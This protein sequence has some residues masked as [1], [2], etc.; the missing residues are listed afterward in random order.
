MKKGMSPWV[1]EVRED[2]RVGTV[3]YSPL[4]GF[5]VLISLNGTFQMSYLAL[6][7][8]ILSHCGSFRLPP[9]LIEKRIKETELSSQWFIFAP[10]SGLFLH[11]HS[12]NK[13]PA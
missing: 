9:A 2:E 7:G 13:P 1:R 10:E 5:N 4:N 6:M 12:R 8:Q 3:E 11:Q